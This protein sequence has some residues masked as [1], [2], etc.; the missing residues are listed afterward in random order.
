M[1]PRTGNPRVA[2]RCDFRRIYKWNPFAN[3]YGDMV[4]QPGSDAVIA[5]VQQI[6]VDMQTHK[7]SMAVQQ[8]GCMV[9]MSIAKEDQNRVL[10][11][12]AGTIE[13]VLDILRCGLIE[14]PTSWHDTLR[15][16]MVPRVHISDVNVNNWICSLLQEISF[17]KDGAIHVVREGGVAAMV[18][19]MRTTNCDVRVWC[20]C[21]SVL[22]NCVVYTAD[23]RHQIMSTGVIETVVLAM[24]THTLIASVQTQACRL[25]MMHLVRTEGKSAYIMKAG[26]IDAVV[27]AMRTFKSNQR[28]QEA[29]CCVLGYIGKEAEHDTYGF[30]MSIST[31]VECAKVVVVAMETHLLI[32]YVQ[33][34]ACTSLHRLFA[35]GT[36]RHSDLCESGYIVAI[37]SAMREHMEN[38]SVELQLLDTLDTLCIF[39]EIC[40][41]VVG[42]GAMQVLLTVLEA[43]TT[44]SDIQDCGIGVIRNIFLSVD[45]ASI[46]A[47]CLV[48]D[49]EIAQPILSRVIEIVSTAVRTHT[50]DE[51]IQIE[52]IGTI[53][54]MTSDEE[55][56]EMLLGGGGVEMV[57]D[58]MKQYT[59]NQEMQYLGC[60]VIARCADDHAFPWRVRTNAMVSVV[61]AMTQTFDE[62]PDQ[63]REAI[64]RNGCVFFSDVVSGLPVTD[65][66]I[67][68]LGGIRMVLAAMWKHPQ[69]VN[70]QLAGL[71]FCCELHQSCMKTL[72]I[73][74]GVN[75]IMAAMATH[76]NVPTVQ[77]DG[78]AALY[79]CSLV[80]KEFMGV[81]RQRCGPIGQQRPPSRAR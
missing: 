26:G 51:Y 65:N 63:W 53:A 16:C 59:S 72:V 40:Q 54:N 76:S 14:M 4:G 49:S 17:G 78:A 2:K 28:L 45:I 30:N 55:C 66:L 24:N 57:A 9:L 81:P 44:C 3:R 31:R 70:I 15:V 73:A 64:Q 32:A 38:K 69:N 47:S 36:L 21:C 34:A 56:I 41:D 43:H 6:L 19:L 39:K 27:A 58:A 25:F 33:A 22:S 11:R 8:N 5:R 80:R 13:V 67:E 29:G 20:L 60:L 52:C 42:A 68:S 71:A 37:I 61:G 48:T 46:R 74:G 77:Q 50:F 35:Y 7:S 10:L 23:A 79:K 1:V 12:K 75:V 18:D 62:E